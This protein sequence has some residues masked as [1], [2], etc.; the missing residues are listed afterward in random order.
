MILTYCV[1]S[2]FVFL[3]LSVM[4]NSTNTHGKILRGFMCF[5]VIFALFVVI[6]ILKA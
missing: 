1:V 6:D 4:V 2:W 5:M 3:I